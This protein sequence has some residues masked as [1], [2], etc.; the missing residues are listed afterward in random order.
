MNNL[1]AICWTRS[2]QTWKQSSI[3]SPKAAFYTTPHGIP[4]PIKP[5]LGWVQL[6][7]HHGGFNHINWVE[8]RPVK[9]P[10]QSSGEANLSELLA[11]RPSFLDANQF[12]V[13]SNTPKY[14][15]PAGKFLANVAPIPYHGPL[16]PMYFTASFTLAPIDCGT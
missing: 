1:P 13:F 3:K 8:E 7:C 4:V 14:T 10:T 9:Y 12:F 16:G 6:I 2:Q 15:E 11:F 5:S